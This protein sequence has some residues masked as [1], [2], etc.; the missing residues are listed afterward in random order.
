MAGLPPKREKK[1]VM[2]ITPS[3]FICM[4][5][6][7]YFSGDMLQVNKHLTSL[8]LYGSC[9]EVQPDSICCAVRRNSTL[10]SLDLSANRFD[11]KSI[12]SLGKILNY[13]VYIG[14]SF[15]QYSACVIRIVLLLINIKLAIYLKKHIFKPIRYKK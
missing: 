4:G 6:S 1:I 7:F 10:T 11:E 8:R 9:L 13:I 12:A 5:T 14:Y 2:C 15:N 3:L